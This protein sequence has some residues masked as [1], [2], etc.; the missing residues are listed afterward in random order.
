MKY[1]NFTITPSTTSG[2]KCFDFWEGD[3]D[4]EGVRRADSIEEAKDVI[5]EV[6][7]DKAPYYEVKMNGRIYPFKWIEDAVG[8]S[9]LWNGELLT[10]IYNP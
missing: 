5:D 2:R 9:L 1:K 7:M 3:Y 4:G 6:V 8:F 10:P